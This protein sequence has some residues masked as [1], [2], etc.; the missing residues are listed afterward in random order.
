[1]RHSLIS[2]AVVMCSA[3]FTSHARADGYCGGA[4]GEDLSSLSAHARE[5]EARTPAYSYAVRTTATYEC[6]SY[7]ANGDLLRTQRPVTAHGTGF[8]F[9]VQGDTTLLL[10]NEHVAEWP[11]VTD[12]DHA[13]DGVPSGCKRIADAL[14]IVDDDRDDYAGDDIPLERVVVDA[15]LDIAI[16]R[17][18][19]KLQVIPWKLG[20]SGNLAPR[21][22]VEVKGFPL[23]AFRAT[24]VGKVISAHD[25]DDFR[26]WDHDDFVV[27]ALL[28]QG[29]SGSPVLAVSCKTGEFELVGVYHARY[30]RG[31]ALNVVVSIDQLRDLI[32][33]L[34]APVRLKTDTPTVLDGKARQILADAA[35]GSGD[36]P[37]F[38]FGALTASVHVR[39]DDTLVF[40]IYSAEFPKVSRPLL[41]LEDSPPG[42]ATAFGA[43]GGAYLGGPHGLRRHVIDGTTGPLLTRALDVARRDALDALAYRGARDADVKSRADAESLAQRKRALE[44]TLSTQGDLTDAIAQLASHATS[45]ANVLSLVEIEAGRTGVTTAA[46]APTLH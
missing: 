3:A 43:L 29:N 34:K 13:V 33:T 10:T 16:L 41:V 7:A 27:D 14:S 38:A 17:A 40:A 1:M 24:N 20:I 45:T 23:G 25:H 22:L 4:Y 30:S 9:R 18:H 46:A 31:S 6:V 26:E 37:F 39:A 8:G 32:T 44:H 2:I 42:D 28:S 5:I 21:D 11:A 15:P 12:D 36:P 19:A 35:R